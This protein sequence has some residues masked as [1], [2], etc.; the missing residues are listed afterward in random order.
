MCIRDSGYTT[1]TAKQLAAYLRGE[2]ELPKKPVILTIDD[3]KYGVYKYMYPLLKEYHMTAVLAVIGE[4]IDSASENLEERAKDPAPFCTWDEIKEMS[5]SGTVEIVSHSYEKHRYNYNGHRGAN[6][7]QSEEEEVFFQAAKMDFQKMDTKLKEITGKGAV[8]FSYPYSYRSD[9]V[10]Y[11]HLDVYKRQP[12]RRDCS[13]ME[14]QIRKV[15][16]LTLWQTL[17]VKGILLK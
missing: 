4:E 13:P 15:R 8:A 17:S 2:E 16:I 7:G 3:G 9:P 10:S 5:L 11:T 12:M 6:I 14:M 1:I